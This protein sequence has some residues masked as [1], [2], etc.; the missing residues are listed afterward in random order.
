M[1]ETLSAAVARGALI[2][3]L[4]AGMTAA[5]AMAQSDSLPAGWVGIALVQHGSDGDASG[6]GVYPV[7]ASVE[8]GSPAQVAGLSAGDT[9]LAYNDVDAHGQPMGMRQFL[10]P[11]ERL[12][13]KVRRN[14][15]LEFPITV[16]R[17][18]A[19]NLAS[20]NV[21]A[22]PV[23][24]DMGALPSL[25]QGGPVT[26]AGPANTPGATALAGAHLMRLNP[27]LASALKVSDKGVLVLDVV[28][29]TAAMQ[30]GLR[31]GDVIVRA[32]GSAVP[33]PAALLQAVRDAS[34]RSIALNVLR[35]GSSQNVTL[36]W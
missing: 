2:A 34:G 1:M 23:D 27:Q 16:A 21:T 26:L 36:R 11:G 3:T 15:V 9:V 33:D 35:G 14:G 32:A 22:N 4:V 13:V 31:A 7:I 6:L 12:V 10:K 18:S 20:L 8:P 30:A 17:R 28:A 5:P 24:A 29:G 19:M 25:M